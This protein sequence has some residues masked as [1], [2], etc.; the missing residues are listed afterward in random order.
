MIEYNL[1][2]YRSVYVRVSIQTKTERGRG[3]KENVRKNL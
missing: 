2:A 1:C 3:K